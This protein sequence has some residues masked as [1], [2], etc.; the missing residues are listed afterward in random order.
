MGRRIKSAET[1]RHVQG[2]VVCN[3]ALPDSEADSSARLKRYIQWQE[4]VAVLGQIALASSDLQDLMSQ[5]ARRLAE[6]L[7]IDFVEVLE[8]EGDGKSLILRAGHGWPGQLALCLCQTR[9][10]LG[11]WPQNAPLCAPIRALSPAPRFLR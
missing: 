3:R 11:Y 9:R 6:V 4:T 8:L 1:S 5:S 2:K 10:G 7:E